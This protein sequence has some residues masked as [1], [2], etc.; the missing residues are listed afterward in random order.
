MLSVKEVAQRL[1]CSTSLVY[2][3]IEAG[4]LRCH[5]IGLGKQGGIRVSEEHLAAYLRQTEGGGEAGSP[6]DPSRLTRGA[7]KHLKL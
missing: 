2:A 3:L 6:P 4:R 5:R 1:R 7:F